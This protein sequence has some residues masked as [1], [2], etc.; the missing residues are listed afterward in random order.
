MMVAPPG[1]SG[2]HAS[3][4]KTIPSI[5]TQQ[6]PRSSL[7]RTTSTQRCTCTR[8][9]KAPSL[10]AHASRS[11]LQPSAAAA[12][13]SCG[14]VCMSNSYGRPRFAASRKRSTRSNVEQSTSTTASP[15]PLSS[16]TALVRVMQGLSSRR[17]TGKTSP[18][19]VSTRTAFRGGSAGAVCT[20]TSAS[21]S[22][23]ARCEA[24]DAKTV[25]LPTYTRVRLPTRPRKQWLEWT[26]RESPSPSPISSS[27]S[28]SSACC[29]RQPVARSTSWA[30]DTETMKTSLSL[31]ISS[32]S[33]LPTCRPST[34]ASCTSR[35]P[36]GRACSSC[37]STLSAASGG[38]SAG[39]R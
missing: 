6:P 16:R 17:C 38:S 35:S 24:L 18:S 34:A 25:E 11:A 9:S 5:V 1:C 31:T 2:S 22:H 39:S 33:H 27:S 23:T 8:S 13:A 32:K 14:S 21:P 26:T 7:C 36:S 12:A 30:P 10:H 28:S 29:G 20:L 37:A 19:L 3:R 4:S 15:E